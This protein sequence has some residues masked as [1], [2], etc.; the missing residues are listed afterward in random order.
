MNTFL[1]KIHTIQK[2]FYEGECESLIVPT[3][4]GSY[5]IM[6]HHSNMVAAL[7]AGE[8]QMKKDGKF[9]HVAVAPGVMEVK[10]N[11][12]TILT[13]TAEYAEE[14][15]VPRAQKQYENALERMKK[16]VDSIEKRLAQ[17]TLSRAIARMKVQASQEKK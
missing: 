13:E 7:S 10:D 16:S 11:V 14:I 17:A 15:D 5:G 3:E 12:V 6:A 8:L 4:D 9:V 2:S 1:L